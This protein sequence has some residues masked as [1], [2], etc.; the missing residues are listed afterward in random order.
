MEHC[1]GPSASIEG[2]NFWSGVTNISS[3]RPWAFMSLV[4]VSVS[5]SSDSTEQ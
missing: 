2:T 4:C 5:P 3:S 1:N